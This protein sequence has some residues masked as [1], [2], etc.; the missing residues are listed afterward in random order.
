M[1]TQADLKRTETSLGP[2]VAECAASFSRSLRAKNRAPMTLKSYLE[3]VRLFG[4][5]L[6]DRGMPTAIDAISREH[7][8]E[9]IIDQQRRHK[10]ATAANRYR[11][12]Q[13]FWKWAVDED[14]IPA[15]PMAKMTPPTI[16]EEPPAVLRDEELRTLLATCEKGKDF[17]S[18]RDHAIIRVMLSTGIRLNELATVCV[19]EPEDSVGAFGLLDM[20]QELVFVIGKGRR[21]RPVPL[22]VKAAQAV[23][24]YLRVRAR[25]PGHREPWLWLGSRGP[26]L[27]NG[28]AQMLARRG[29]QA[30]IDRKL[31]PHMFRHSFAHSYLSKGG[32]EGDLMRLTGWRSRQ[33]LQRYAAATATD[34]ALE[35]HRRLGIGD[36]L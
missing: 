19:S 14:E 25:H 17:E 23:G 11:S 12:L 22:G 26:L 4:E 32:Q 30:G 36:D 21:P 15:S 7:V 8:E 2:T 35:A 9:F 18:R 28:I 6:A 13:A 5:F 20:E 33:M 1:A 31:H 29:R 34:R 27:D 10:P 24:R 16:P 3:A